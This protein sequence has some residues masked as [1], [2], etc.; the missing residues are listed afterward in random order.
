MKI[1]LLLLCVLLSACNPYG[2]L[3]PTPPAPPTITVTVAPSIESPTPRPITQSTTCKV[4]T[5]IDAGKLNLRTGAGVQYAIM[6]VLHEGEI[7]TVI[8]R[9]DGNWYEVTDAQGD[10]GFINSRYCEGA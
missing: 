2:D 3:Y 8:E 9:G 1:F 4:K 7:L 5:G 10:H 6:R